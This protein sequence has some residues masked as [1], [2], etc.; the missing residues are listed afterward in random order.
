VYG[1]LGVCEGK[2]E[3][4]MGLELGLEGTSVKCLFTHFTWA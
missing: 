3:G 1:W 2:R 4:G